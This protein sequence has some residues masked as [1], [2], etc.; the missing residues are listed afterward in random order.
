MNLRTAVA[1]LA[2]T[3][4]TALAAGALMAGPAIAAPAST[5]LGGAHLAH[6][7]TSSKIAPRDGNTATS[8]SLSA[9]QIA[10][11]QEN[12]EVINAGV[13]NTGGPSSSPPRGTIKILEGQTVICQFFFGTAGGSCSP[14]DSELSV[15]AHT[16]TAAY[17]GD[18]LNLPSVS[19]PVILT[20]VKQQPTL[21]LNLSSPTAT[22]GAESG[23]LMTIGVGAF[24]S[25]APTGALS[26]V[27]NGVTL[28]HA[29]LEPGSR[30]AT[31]RFADVQLPAGGHDLTAIYGG[32]GNFNSA[33]SAAQHLIVAQD[34]TATS[35]T[36]LPSSTLS[37]DQEA[38]ARL[39]YQISPGL[40]VG[41]LNPTG[42]ITISTDTTVLCTQA[43]NGNGSCP[44]TTAL[45]PGTYHVTAAYSGDGNFV[46]STSAP[47]TLTITA[48]T[49]PPAA[50]TSTT[51]ALSAGRAVFGHEQAEKLSVQ[52]ASGGGTPAGTVTVKTGSTTV[53]TITLAS[54]KGSCTL[55]ATKLRPG[56]YPLVASYAGSAAFR[57]SSSGSRIL[58]VA[59]EPTSTS[60][61]LSAAKVKAG[62]E[63]SEKLSV[64]VKPKFSGTPA[65]K[66]TIKAGAAKVCVITLKSGKGSCTLKASQ[67][68][69]GSYK[70]A[71]SYAAAAPYAGSASAKKTLTVTK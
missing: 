25:T 20:V 18:G 2:A 13:A 7:A 28:C 65:G 21:A 15:G 24:G 52:V 34:P 59:A 47:V 71:A 48:N 10:F 62:H 66:V 17:G 43:V 44:L 64:Q 23:V 45:L 56:G 12:N 41:I 40:D 1:A 9:H 36:P 27:E 37:V 61:A 19:T 16:L 63:Q 22:L 11:G 6:H 70:L 57:A 30:S 39:S 55:G 35:V 8:I 14:T 3:A 67:L 60:L 5:G 4:S 54:G 29:N 38:G 32:D 69:A 33:Q 50:P 53:C 51:L 26:V 49:P 31:C 58:T 46:G 42:M 68:K